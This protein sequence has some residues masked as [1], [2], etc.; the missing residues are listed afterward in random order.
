MR[1][2][3]RPGI[4]WFFS[5]LSPAKKNANI[6]Y[7]RL[8]VDLVYNGWYGDRKYFSS[9]WTSIGFNI[10]TMFDIPMTR[11]GLA[12]FGIG[13]TYSHLNNRSA[14][15]FQRD[16]TNKTT[17]V[18]IPPGNNPTIKRRHFGANFI[19]IPI[20][21]RLRTKGWQHFKIMIGG[22]F[23]YNFNSYVKHTKTIKDKK[24]KI[25][26]NNFP[27]LNPFRYGVTLRLG[28]R[29]WAIFGAYYF[30]PL[31]KNSNSTQLYPFSL[32]ITISLF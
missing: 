5:G 32:G 6:K 11:N 4:F 29:N 23:G 2:R 19:E 27:D 13:L 25:I 9:P 10:S 7:D 21:F 8:M 3:Y 12:S 17:Q 22:K 15:D 1:S 30:S 28:I 24:Y 18:K 14:I 16:F 20:E 31:F 26:Q